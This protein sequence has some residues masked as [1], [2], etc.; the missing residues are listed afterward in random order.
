MSAQPLDPLSEWQRFANGTASRF[1]VAAQELETLFRSVAERARQSAAGVDEAVARAELNRPLV[2]DTG[3]LLHRLEREGP[4]SL[5]TR[6]QKTLVSTPHALRPDHLDAILR[7]SPPL[8]RHAGRVC[9]AHWHNYVREPWGEIYLRIVPRRAQPHIR[10]FETSLPL[11]R[12]LT[13]EAPAGDEQVAATLPLDRVTDAYTQLKEQLRVRDTWS[14]SSSVLTSWVAARAREGA[15]LDAHLQDILEH[16]RLRALLLPASR[17]AAAGPPVRSSVAA[18]VGVLVTA[19]E[20]GLARP[21]RLQQRATLGRLLHHVLESTFEDPRSALRS[22]GWSQV[23]RQSPEAFRDLLSS[24]CQQDLEF[25]FDHAMKE[26]DR[27][28]F[29]LGYLSEIERTGCVLDRVARRSMSAKLHSAP[30]LQSALDRA[31]SFAHASTAHAFFL[32]FRSIVVVEFSVDGHAAYVYRRD[33]FAQKIEPLIRSN[34]IES[35]RSLQWKQH[36]IHRITHGG[37]WQG[38]AEEW[39]R[40][41]GVHRR[42]R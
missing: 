40:G 31:F 26:P 34:R 12:L 36:A 27:R 16:D 25:F 19:L 9:L 8:A 33:F 37:R 23:E 42:G 10:L 6:E 22:E 21:P 30:E 38:S 1:A 32:V 24:L 41:E 35:S 17:G 2:V 5:T 14:F 7:V 3:E 28:K 11:A 18:Q 39:L 15:F 29:W 13:R 4:A 20:A